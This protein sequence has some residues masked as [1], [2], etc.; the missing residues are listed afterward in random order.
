MNSSI[1]QGRLILLDTSVLIHLIRQN[2]LGQS[3]E[4]TYRLS[5][6]VE[7]P[8]IST[9][10]EGELFGLAHHLTWGAPRVKV[11]LDLLN[12]LVRVEAGLP[13]VIQN[14]ATLY[15]ESRRTGSAIG[16]N[17]L[18]IAASARAANALLLT[19]DRDFDWADQLG[20]LERI[21]ISTAP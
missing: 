18:W 1:P 8:L 12:E 10:T 7:R 17:D 4:S 6:R 13:E 5:S 11:L 3:I 14:Y 16:Q 21:W 20:L 19:C 2:P 15:A 9:V